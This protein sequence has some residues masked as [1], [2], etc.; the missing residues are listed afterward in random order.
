MG[1]AGGSGGALGMGG[2]TTEEEAGVEESG[3]SGWAR[4]LL[5]E[6]T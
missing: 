1:G 2:G 5:F 6:E 4:V 3:V